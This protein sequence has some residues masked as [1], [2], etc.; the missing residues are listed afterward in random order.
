MAP[1]EFVPSPRRWSPTYQPRRRSRQLPSSLSFIPS[2]AGPRSESHEHST[3]MPRRPVDRGPVCMSPFRSVRRM[4]E[5][6]QL[7][8]PTSPASFDGVPQF[9][10]EKSRSPKLFSDHTLRTW[11]S[12]QNLTSANLE[13][14]G[15]LPSPPMSDSRPA[16]T[17][18]R[19]SYF[20]RKDDSNAEVEDASQEVALSGESICTD[21]KIKYKAYR[22]PEWEDTEQEDKRTDVKNIHEA[23]SNLVRQCEPTEQ[24]SLHA[25]RRPSP[26]ASPELA[27]SERESVPG[28]SPRVQRPRTATI[29]SEVS[30][31]PSNFSYC[32]RWLQRV[33]LE[34]WDDKDGLPPEFNWRKFQIVQQD[35]PMPKLDIIPGAKA[36]DEPV[37]SSIGRLVNIRSADHPT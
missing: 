5:P 25:D 9:S 21:E 23:H 6:F 26:S 34:S 33:P 10:D 12:D 2:S 36:L 1:G 27:Q 28:S 17:E 24:Q 30:W 31:I 35:P 14:F 3:S 37:V 11:R 8:L 20:E 15:L 16:S 19:T 4:K 29:S 22:P 13:A 18:P 32:E 7:V